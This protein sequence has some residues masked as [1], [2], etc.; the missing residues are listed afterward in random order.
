MANGLHLTQ[1][2]KDLFA[3]RACYK[4]FGKKRLSKRIDQKKE[5]AKPYGMNP[6]QAAARKADKKSKK[7]AN[8]VKS[9]PEVSRL[10]ALQPY[11]NK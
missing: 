1:K 7:G 6:M 3:T 2:H 5:A 4:P 8:K 10:G 11:S 9:R